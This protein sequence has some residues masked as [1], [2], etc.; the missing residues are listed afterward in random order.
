MA[1]CK[2]NLPDNSATAKEER[3]LRAR[4]APTRTDSPALTQR[5]RL[6]R[7]AHVMEVTGLKRTKTY[8]L[9]AQG[10]FPMRVQITPTCVG[11]L[12]HE[13]QAWIAKRVTASA[14]LVVRSWE[15]SLGRAR[16]DAQADTK[17]AN[18]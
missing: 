14:P 12:E 15:R 9:Q 5:I 2:R 10:D 4:I 17:R 7:L 11:W 6:L 13:V 18:P 8:A 1:I 3:A 16:R